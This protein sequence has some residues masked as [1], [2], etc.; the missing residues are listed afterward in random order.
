MKRYQV[1]QIISHTVVRDGARVTDQLE[2]TVFD[3]HTYDACEEWIEDQDRPNEFEI[4]DT[5]EEL[6]EDE[7]EPSL[8]Y[9]GMS[10]DEEDEVDEEDLFDED[11]DEEIHEEDYDIFNDGDGDMD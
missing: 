11:E 1:V 3:A 7:D 2:E 5:D 4:V 8:F 10:Y 6:E 9:S